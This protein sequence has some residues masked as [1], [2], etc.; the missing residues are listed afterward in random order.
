MIDYSGKDNASKRIKIWNNIIDLCSDK[1]ECEQKIQE[2]FQYQNHNEYYNK[3]DG[4]HSYLAPYATKGN[5][6]YIQ[7]LDIQELI[8]LL[9]NALID[10]EYF[11]LKIDKKNGYNYKDIRNQFENIKKYLVNIDEVQIKIP[12]HPN[13][14]Y[15]NTYHILIEKYNVNNNDVTEIL[16]ILLDFTKKAKNLITN[17]KEYTDVIK[18][19]KKLIE[20]IQTTEKFKL[21]SKSEQDVSL[22]KL[23]DRIEILKSH[24]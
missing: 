17:K 2:L 16:N 11:N 6:F 4:L 13:I 1:I 10:Y 3:L 20:H 22:K 23:N 7:N 18:S 12:T 9:M 19:F 21:K 15:N 24:I 8:F 5:D 14:I